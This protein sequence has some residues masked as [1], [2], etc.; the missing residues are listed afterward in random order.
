MRLTED[1]KSVVLDQRLGFVATV[2][3]DGRP[4]LSPKG[5][6]A[7]FDDEH[8]VFADIASP[9]TVE[10][11]LATPFVEINV[12]DPIKRKGYRFKGRGSVHSSG[13]IFERGVALLAELGYTTDRSRIR[14]IVLV[15]VESAAP[16]ISPAYATGATEG[17]VASSWLRRFNELNK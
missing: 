1:M 8:L 11:L 6:T 9:K 4:N 16:I 2:S 14:S 17:E 3:R 5:T 13:D 12:V 10:N 15:D 7:V